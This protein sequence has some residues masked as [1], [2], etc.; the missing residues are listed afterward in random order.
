MLNKR[1]T[2]EAQPDNSILYLLTI[3]HTIVN[4][5]EHTL[6]IYQLSRQCWFYLSKDDFMGYFVCSPSFEGR[7][8][9]ETHNLDSLSASIHSSYLRMAKLGTER[10]PPY[11]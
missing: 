6:D 7:D 2:T 9:V 5:L 3:F 11:R 10:V 8:P 4:I 1:C